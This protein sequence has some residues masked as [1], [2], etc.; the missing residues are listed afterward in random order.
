M[1]L[2]DI[3]LTI[4]LEQLVPPKLHSIS[5]SPPCSTIEVGND[6]CWAAIRQTGEGDTVWHTWCPVP[7]MH[8]TLY[9]LEASTTLKL[10]V[11]QIKRLFEYASVDELIMYLQFYRDAFYYVSSLIFS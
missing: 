6:N 10:P 5:C 9:Q 3:T 8:I 7:H 4:Q 2:T 11:T 1:E